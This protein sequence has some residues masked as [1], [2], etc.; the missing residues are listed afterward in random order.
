MPSSIVTQV[1]ALILSPHCVS[2]SLSPAASLHIAT[3]LSLLRLLSLGTNLVVADTDWKTK[4]GGGEEGEGGQ[5]G[6]ETT[7]QQAGVEVAHARSE[8]V[9]HVVDVVGHPQQTESGED[10]EEGGHGAGHQQDD[11]DHHLQVEQTSL[12][13]KCKPAL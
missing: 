12:W 9:V 4:A 8:P 5:A 7:C 2:Q 11:H 10:G 6:E 3:I 13:C 1:N